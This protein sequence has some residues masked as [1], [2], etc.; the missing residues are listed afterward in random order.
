[1]KY[2]LTYTEDKYLD[3]VIIGIRSD[4]TIDCLKEKLKIAESNRDNDGNFKFLGFRFDEHDINFALMTLDDYFTSI[5][6]K[7]TKII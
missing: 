3:K 5:E 4:E 2:I 1:M 7:F 6:C